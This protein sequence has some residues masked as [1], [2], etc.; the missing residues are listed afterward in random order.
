ML[1]YAR[2]V[3]GCYILNLKALQSRQ[4]RESQFIQYH[5]VNHLVTSLE[6]VNKNGVYRPH[7]SYILFLF[8]FNL[9][10]V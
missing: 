4:S 6:T 8:C 5:I 2:E 3:T 1:V 9:S 7:L 10:M